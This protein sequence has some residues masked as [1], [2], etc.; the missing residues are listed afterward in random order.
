MI[1]SLHD[2]HQRATAREALATTDP[3]LGHWIRSLGD[4][5]KPR[6]TSSF[7]LLCH[8][9]VNQQISVKAGATIGRRLREVAGGRLDPI[10]LTRLTDE[11]LIACGLSRQ[12]RAAL[13]DLAERTLDGRLRPDQLWRLDDA[14]AIDAIVTVRGLGRWSAEMFLIFGL[15]RPDVFSD[16]DLGLRNAM[17]RLYD[18]DSLPGIEQLNA[19]AQAWRPWRTLAS[20]Y[21]W[22]SLDPEGWKPDGR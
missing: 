9:I 4:V 21:L 16:S 8:T 11:E 14:S 6:R 10:I 19:I 15:G 1:A 18:L 20:C 3:L 7:A 17:V 13:R 12:K 5:W 22:A 2:P